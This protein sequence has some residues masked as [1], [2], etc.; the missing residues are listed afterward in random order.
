M[1]YKVKFLGFADLHVVNQPTQEGMCSVYNRIQELRA[2]N[3]YSTI[4]DAT[5]IGLLTEL[6]KDDSLK[7]STIMRDYVYSHVVKESRTSVGQWTNVIIPFLNTVLNYVL[8]CKISPEGSAAFVLEKKIAIVTADPFIPECNY[9]TDCRYKVKRLI[10]ECCAYMCIG[11]SGVR[12]GDCGRW[13]T[14]L[15]PEGFSAILTRINGPEWKACELPSG[16]TKCVIMVLPKIHS[17]WLF[18]ISGGA[19]LD[20]PLYVHIEPGDT[21]DARHSVFEGLY[22]RATGKIIVYDCAVANGIDIR[23]KCLTYRIDIGAQTSAWWRIGHNN[24]RISV[25]KYTPAAMI[26]KN[27]AKLVLFVRDAAPLGTIPGNDAFFWK[28]PTLCKGQYVLTC[29][30]D[31]CLATAVYGHCI[32]AE[33]GRLINPSTTEHMGT[34]VCEVVDVDSEFPV[35][36]AVRVAKNSERLF[37]YDEC[38]SSEY[39]RTQITTSGMSRLLHQISSTRTPVFTV[40]E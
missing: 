36:R 30:M 17:A 14:R 35:W 4:I 13:G 27:I 15:V 37:T 38:F 20:G 6:I 16:L 31:R 39:P 1:Y 33:V 12:G 18:K 29:R 3:I 28:T 2:S 22:D 24:S 9:N 26:D 19:A 25:A 5:P 11:A 34:Y 8:S 32:L 23:Q 10:A 7:I 21:I 40:D